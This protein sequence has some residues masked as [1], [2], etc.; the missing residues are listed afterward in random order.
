MCIILDNDVK[1][2]VVYFFDPLLDYLLYCKRRVRII[3]IHTHS[4]TNL[5]FLLVRVGTSVLLLLSVLMVVGCRL[6]HQI[7]N[8]LNK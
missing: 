6:K 1:V 2:K 8:I 7:L 3:Y 4:V 5:H